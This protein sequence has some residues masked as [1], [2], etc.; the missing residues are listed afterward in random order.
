MIGSS[1]NPTIILMSGGPDSSILAAYVAQ[2]KPIIGLH[3]MFGQATATQEAVAAERVARFYGVR[4]ETIDLQGTF[5][6]F[7]GTP[8]YGIA[9]DTISAWCGGP[10]VKGLYG[11]GLCL[12]C[13]YAA[14]VGADTIAYAIQA[15]DLAPHPELGGAGN[16]AFADAMQIALGQRV[17]IETPFS[18]NTKAEVFGYGQQLNAPFELTWSC[19][20]AEQIHCGECE[21]CQRRKGAFT[22]AGI[23]DPTPYLSSP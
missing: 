23:H 1:Q 3:I 14:A 9:V 15:D 16:Q 12:G 8:R 11:V 21:S 17:E 5:R 13:S 20:R 6:L 10:L 2:Q 19:L 4:L 22:A 18:S 7:Y